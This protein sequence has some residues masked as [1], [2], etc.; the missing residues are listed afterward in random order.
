MKPRAKDEPRAKGEPKGEAEPRA[1]DE[2][3]AK[4]EPKDEPKGEA[5]PRARA[6]PKD[7]PKG[8]AKPRAKAEPK[9]EPKGEA[10]PRAK[11]EPRA[12]AE[13][14][15]EAK[16]TARAKPGDGVQAQPAPDAQ[17]NADPAQ[18]E[19][20][21]PLEEGDP[22]R[23]KRKRAATSSAFKIDLPSPALALQPDSE[24][25]AQPPGSV[26]LP[27]RS[28]WPTYAALTLGVS[29]AAAVGVAGWSYLDR[30]HH[31]AS[32]ARLEAE[33]KGLT[34][35]QLSFRLER[36]SPDLRED[37]R[38]QALLAAAAEE[39][40]A[41]A[42][43]EQAARILRRTPPRSTL[44]AR[45]KHALEALEASPSYAP[46]LLVCARVA[47]VE[48]LAKADP[49]RPTKEVLS[50]ALGLLY[51]AE[52]A[53]PQDADVA[54]AQ[55]LLRLRAGDTSAQ[56]ALR[57]AAELS[58]HELQGRLAR[59]ELALL[60]GDSL[61]A[62]EA[63]SSA[64][65]LEATH[66]RALWGRGEAQRRLG[67]YEDAQADARAAIQSDPHLGE[68]QVLLGRALLG[69][70]GDWRQPQGEALEAVRSA[71]RRALEIYPGDGVSLGHLALLRIQLDTRG[72][73]SASA[74]ERQE[75]EAQAQAALRRAP[76]QAA[77]WSVLATLAQARGA[78]AQVGAALSKG[79]PAAE[80]QP[81]ALR[82]LLIARVRVEQGEPG[83]LDRIVALAP[84][85]PYGHL[86]RARA[87]QRAGQLEE[88]LRD[89]SRALQ[90]APERK[91]LLALRAEWLLA[92]DPPR[93]AAALYDLDGYLDATPDDGEVFLRR[94]ELL[95]RAEQ[96]EEAVR[97]LE[98]ARALDSK[99]SPEL[100][101]RAAA[102]A[103]FARE[104][105]ARA[106]QAYQALL[107]LSPPPADADAL[108]ERLRYAQ[109]GASGAILLR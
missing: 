71:F 79:L 64:L 82:L 72:D 20:A 94:A 107:E 103:A 1:K 97:D 54:L 87:R 14:K 95:V 15:G 23:A 81:R 25:D 108:R 5:K 70:G 73:L 45:R 80:A 90:A 7:E 53:A 48:A 105:W 77:A 63:F 96:P 83:D 59:G 58:P 46:A 91:D 74:A 47:E 89:L 76:L 36:S 62:Y 16:P 10:K 31:E 43:Q 24:S 41:L 44:Q 19:R 11:D 32:V 68:A 50:E 84:R 6:E 8:E 35:D 99:P 109:R 104:E 85:E 92:L 3:R 27:R 52:A 17:V 39:A 18:K 102:G 93:L 69:E 13:S 4:A 12:K 106:A 60:R 40:A 38:V 88:A 29:V 61:N 57:K 101:L 37:P 55:G 100:S 65:A 28:R 2:P 86:L 22:R 26:P 30:Q 66:A 67:R 33:A 78:R 56:E 21:E 51:R 75:I 9:D 34:L 42:G 98:R 49:A